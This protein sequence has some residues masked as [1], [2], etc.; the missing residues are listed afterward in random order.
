SRS[1]WRAGTRTPQHGLKTE[2]SLSSPGGSITSIIPCCLTFAMNLC[3]TTD[4]GM[5]SLPRSTTTRFSSGELQPKVLEQFEAFGQTA[6]IHQKEKK[7]CSSRSFLTCKAESAEC[8]DMDDNKDA[9]GTR[10]L[11]LFL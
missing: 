7:R 8:A 2:V 10:C 4:L 6:T 11:K 5:L 9:V 3:D 1:N